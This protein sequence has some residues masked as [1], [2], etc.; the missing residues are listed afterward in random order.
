MDFRENFK[1]RLLATFRAEAQD[2]I[3]SILSGLLEL[4][5]SPPPSVSLELI[6]TVYRSSHS[7]KGAARAVNMSGI[8]SICQSLEGIFSDWKRRGVEPYKASFDTVYRAVETMRAVLSAPDGS[9]NAEVLA[10]SAV[11]ELASID[12]SSNVAHRRPAPKAGSDAPDAARGAQIARE[13]PTLNDTVRISN[14]RLNSLLLQSEEML[15]AKLSSRQHAENLRE[16]ASLFNALKKE[17]D[18]AYV[19]LL[20]AF[21]AAQH[22][23]GEKASVLSKM[24]EFFH[25]SEAR[26]RTIEHRLVS[27]AKATVGFNRSFERMVDGLLL[28]M[29]HAAMLPFST[30]LES[31]PMA[32]RNI[33]HEQGKEVDLAVSGESVEV[34]RRILESIKDPLLH[35]L[36][37]SIDHG[38]EAPGLRLLH[39]KPRRGTISISIS[40]VEGN[41]ASITVADDGAGIDT[42]RLREAAVSHGVI[43]PEEAREMTDEEALQLIFQSGLSTSPIVT[44][45]SGRG[46]GLAI[47]RE[48]VE[49]LGGSVYVSTREG[50]GTEFR[51]ML[52]LTIATFRGVLIRS[53]GHSFIIPTSGIERTM[54]VGAGEIKTVE[55]RETISIDGRP[56]SF[57]WLDAVLELPAL[58]P[59]PEKEGKVPVV[60]LSFGEKTIAFGVDEIVQEQEVLAKPLGPQLQK[61]R[62]VAGAAVLGSGKPVPVLNTGDLVR[63]AIKARPPVAAPAREEP[64]MRS[65]LVVEDSITSRVLLQSILETAGYTVKTAV[66]G[67]EAITMLK[68]EKFDIVVSDVEMPRMNGFD[69]TSRIR[70]EKNLKDLPV[71]LV[72]AL[73]TREDRERGI[74][75]GANAYIV[76]SS[77][78]Q[79]NLLEVIK[80][81]I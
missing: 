51:I 8:E 18:Q 70:R 34:D 77:F 68:S 40:A 32:V 55:N 13:H 53:A 71:V 60:V 20:P 76:K 65:V 56:A 47:A 30:L 15:T 1:K 61:V 75:V 81:F 69:L 45:L 52:P 24:Q 2:H 5:K 25:D 36:R 79:G 50:L 23:R 42:G 54:R 31:F 3:K 38:I 44:D 80:R 26:I 21:A 57:V 19:E 48:N 14:E 6:E 64:K 39:K 10:R 46:L 9:E 59:Q 62:N 58:R 74:D 63:G 17:R 33:S 66:D 22:G 37:N 43:R 67:V 16:L 72:T 35:M 11:E 4:E 41:K 29:K 78:D 49:R 12:A 27:I 7:L 28:D 73:E